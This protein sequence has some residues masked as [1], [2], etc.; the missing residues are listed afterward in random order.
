[1]MVQIFF[2]MWS[3]YNLMQY[4]RVTR[5]ALLTLVISCSV[6]SMMQVLRIATTE[7]Y[8][9]YTGPRY[10]VL[11]QNPNN[12]G[13]NV[14]LGLIALFGFAFGKNKTSSWSKYV[15][16]PLAILMVSAIFDTA[17]R[18]ALTAFGFG[19][20]PF[21]IRGKTLWAKAKSVII[22]AAAVG[23]LI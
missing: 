12:L 17:S 18:G 21:A 11:G 3:G 1:L 15:L 14:S 20:V 16:A 8:D 22:V 23:I 10:A 9:F 19:L 2:L 7:S 4:E 6:I 13:N 5:T